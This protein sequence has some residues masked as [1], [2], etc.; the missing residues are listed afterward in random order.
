MI[1]EYHTY[2]TDTDFDIKRT[3]Y[4][5][6]I[7]LSIDLTIKVP[8][9]FGNLIGLA[10]LTAPPVCMGFQEIEIYFF[11]QNSTNLDGNN[12][13]REKEQED[14]KKPHTMQSE[15]LGKW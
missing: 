10:T 1:C 12:S 13:R 7:L 5:E 14:K 2:I 6:S 3:S 15:R 11:S 9:F 8:N 4:K